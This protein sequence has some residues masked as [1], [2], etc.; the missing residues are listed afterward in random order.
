MAAHIG[1]ADGDLHELDIQAQI[2]QRPY[3]GG[4]G[5]A[6]GVIVTRSC[7]NKTAPRAK[8][9]RKKTNVPDFVMLNTLN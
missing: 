5:R 1:D 7:A 9:Y 2:R 3:Y 8:E 6:R 4:A